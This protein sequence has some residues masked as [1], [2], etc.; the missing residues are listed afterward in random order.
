M[1][2]CSCK[3]VSQHMD[4]KHI[5]FA[6][7][8]EADKSQC[9]SEASG[10][11]PKMGNVERVTK[12]SPLLPLWLQVKSQIIFLMQEHHQNYDLIWRLCRCEMHHPRQGLYKTEIM[13]QINVIHSQEGETLF[14][15]L[16][17]LVILHHDTLQQFSY[18]WTKLPWI[19]TSSCTA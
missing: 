4:R 10:D 6:L 2:K 12:C 16:R 14:T 5:L 19:I 8:R 1:T 3:H 18:P 7:V 11:Y 13:G 17:A 15:C 9:L